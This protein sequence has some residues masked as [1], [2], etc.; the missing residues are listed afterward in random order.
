MSLAHST[1]VIL[2]GSS[3]IGLSTAWRSRSEIEWELDLL[4]H[5]DRKG[6]PVAAPVAKKDGIFLSFLNQPEGQ[7]GAALFSYAEGEKPSEL[8]EVHAGVS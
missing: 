1:V 8:K 3:G 2:G 6:V 4:I 5:L 7:R